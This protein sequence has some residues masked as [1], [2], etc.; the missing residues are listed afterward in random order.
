MR[1]TMQRLV[2]PPKFNCPQQR[3]IK[4]IHRQL[5]LARKPS[6]SPAPIGGPGVGEPSLGAIYRIETNGFF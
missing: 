4:K 6:L 2:R 3:P 5:K 1:V